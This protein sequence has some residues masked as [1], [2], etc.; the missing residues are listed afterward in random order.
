[1]GCSCCRGKTEDVRALGCVFPTKGRLEVKTK[2]M[3][4]K[5]TAD[6]SL[7]RK[8]A[9]LRGRASQCLEDVLSTVG[10]ESST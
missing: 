2:M 8:C 7:V 1:M 6:G 5:A 3:C 4:W 9:V 10:K